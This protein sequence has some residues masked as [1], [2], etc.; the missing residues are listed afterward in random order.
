[1]PPA[2][3]AAGIGAVG[4]I[5]GGLIASSGAK[6]AANAQAQSN[7]QGIAEQRRQFDLTRS[8]FKPYMDAGKTALPQIEDLLGLNGN[9][10]SAAAIEALKSSPAYQS[11]YNN[12]QEAVLQNAA[13]TG[14][15]RGGNTQSSLAN[16]GRD[17]LSSVI[18][19]QLSRLGGLAGM[20][21]GATGSVAGLGANTA[22]QISSLFQATGN[23][24]ASSA[25]T[26]AGIWSGVINNIGGL[27]Q[28]VVNPAKGF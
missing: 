26:Q 5:G 9:D 4:A 18:S 27:A 1:M 15:L 14:G 24:R 17:T 21:Q 7:A 8:D 28:G 3:V 22:N 23:A 19:D 13:A 11:L 12:G 16:F 2:I 25:L 10:K 6:S 20:G